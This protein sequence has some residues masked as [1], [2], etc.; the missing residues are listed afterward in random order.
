MIGEHAGV[1][2]RVTGHRLAQLGAVELQR[3]A[4]LPPRSG[5]GFP[6]IV[7]PG[8]QIEQ[9]IQVGLLAELF[10][11]EKHHLLLL[12]Q[13]QRLGGAQVEAAMRRDHQHGP[14][15]QLGM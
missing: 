6:E 14:V 8:E 2:L 13:L 3:L 10:H 11:A 1:P 4:E 12:K 15:L 9:G 5:L 7:C